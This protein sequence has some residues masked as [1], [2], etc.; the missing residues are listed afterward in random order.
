MTAL[1]IATAYLASVT[2]GIALAAVLIAASGRET[3]EEEGLD[4]GAIEGDLTAFV[5]AQNDALAAKQSQPRSCR[6]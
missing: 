5:Q 6:D 4:M 1:T 2:V 3:R